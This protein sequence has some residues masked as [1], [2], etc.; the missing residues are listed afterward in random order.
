MLFV[1]AGTLHYNSKSDRRR[2]TSGNERSDMISDDGKYSKIKI[3][4]AYGSLQFSSDPQLDGER[5]ASPSLFPR[6]P[7]LALGPSSLPFQSQ[8]RAH[9]RVGDPSIE[10]KR[11]ATSTRIWI[12]TWIRTRMHCAFCAIVDTAFCKLKRVLTGAGF[13]DESRSGPSQ[14]NVSGTWCLFLAIA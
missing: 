6:T 11:D 9:C 10:G 2:Y 8:G 1:H 3:F 7:T 14:A 12:W 13:W 4:A 5:G